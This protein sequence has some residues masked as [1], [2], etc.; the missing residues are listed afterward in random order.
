MEAEEE[1]EKTPEN[2]STLSQWIRPL[3]SLFTAKDNGPTKTYFE[4]TSEELV[5][6]REEILNQ[7]N[8]PYIA[9]LIVKVMMTIQIS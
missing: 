9:T 7:P 2:Q 6:A 3:T 4:L 1:E 8:V 5:K